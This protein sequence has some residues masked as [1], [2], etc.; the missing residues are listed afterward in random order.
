MWA[1]GWEGESGGLSEEPA[2]EPHEMECIDELFVY[3]RLV[4]HA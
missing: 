3:G 1:F 2:D 4:G